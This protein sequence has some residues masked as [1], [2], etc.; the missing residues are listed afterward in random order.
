MDE[1]IRNLIEERARTWEQAKALL[2]RQ[3]VEGRG[4]NAE[5]NEQFERMTQAIS[6]LDARIDELH[7]LNVANKK[8]DAQRAEYESIVRPEIRVSQEQSQDREIRELIEGKRRY[9]ELDM[10]GLGVQPATME[11]K[12][13]TRD[14]L[15]V[16]DGQGGYTVPTGFVRSL[17]EHLVENSAIRQ[18]NVR[19][20]ST[21]SG[22][23]LQFPKVATLGTAAIVGEGSAIGETT[24][25][26]GQVTLGAWKYSALTQVSSELMQDTGVNLLDFL[27]RDLGRA[28]GNASGAHFITGDGSNKPYGVVNATVAQVGTAVQGTD[29]AIQADNL[30]D[31]FYAVQAG[32]A[33]RGYWLMRRATE[34]QIRKLK[35]S[36]NNY[37][38]Q[39]GLQAG[40]PN[41]LLGRPIVNDPNVAARASAAASVIFGDFSGYVIR[42]VGSI[43]LE[44]SDDYAF[45]ADLAT[46]RAILR[47]DGDL[48]DTT[49]AI[50]VMDTDG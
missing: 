42:D 50:K 16:T 15:K 14:L 44:R 10:R 36:D 41:L 31:L 19:V 8:I 25:S 27:A 45:N 20:V 33:N 49:G 9:V 39:P 37:L 38:W 4:L 43:R 40:S 21:A 2:S 6:E 11:G 29:T 24:Q 48:V 28:L 46:W 13:Q 30:V 7:T 5:E 17:Y 23:N 22:E 1:M 47:T 32:Y 35:G 26:F 18:T 34:G 3:D 12:W